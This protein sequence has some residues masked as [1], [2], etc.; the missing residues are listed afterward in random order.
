[1]SQKSA[2]IRRKVVGAVGLN[3]SGKD[4]LIQYLG[5]RCGLTVLSL[6]D[7]A[8]E[9]AHLEGVTSSRDKLHEVSL[10]YI[11]RYGE[12]FFVKV[13]I[14]EIDGKVMEKV[15]V[16]GIRTPTDVATLRQHFGAD[17]LLIHVK[18]DNPKLRFE[19]LQQRGEARDDPQN[20]DQS[21]RA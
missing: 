4:A 19:R 7:V 3:G 10:K 5:D 16:T 9:L 14:E 2:E 6:G 11:E 8:R 20:P 12:D 21:R 13:L 17:F 18:V 1:M 15:G